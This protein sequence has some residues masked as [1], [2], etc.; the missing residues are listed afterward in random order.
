MLDQVITFDIPLLIQHDREIDTDL[1]P[2]FR[3]WTE[4]QAEK[5]KD[6]LYRKMIANVDE[7]EFEKCLQGYQRDIFR[8][9]GL[10]LNYAEPEDLSAKLPTESVATMVQYIYITLQD[11][12]NF[13][14]K[15]FSKYFDQDS[16]VP[17]N[18]KRI[19]KPTIAEEIDLLESKLLAAGCMSALVEVVM[20]PIHR[21]VSELSNNET[22]YRT[23]IYVK[24]LKGTLLAVL[25]GKGDP[26]EAL[27]RD[28]IYYLNFNCP[29]FIRYQIK[30]L[31][32]LRDT[33]ADQEIIRQLK[34][35]R[36]DL[37]QA[38]VKLIVC[39]S[40]EPGIVK[41]TTER[42]GR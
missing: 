2:A 38:Q 20:R 6:G 42:L 41:S 14:E 29:D 36:K 31:S 25:E 27:I 26:N 21:F 35:F 13:I 17:S 34:R 1:V 18:F 32:L 7:K 23:I 19:I 12:L 30:S 9:A 5:I 33:C 39:P 37:N 15:R 11:I 22:N 28:T 4:N 40:P 10:L 24:E 3:T 16:W 8:L